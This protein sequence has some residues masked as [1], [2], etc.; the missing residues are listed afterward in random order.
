MNKMIK[1]AVGGALVAS[2]LAMAAP[3]SAGQYVNAQ[4][5]VSEIGNYTYG[6][7]NN[8]SF[9]NGLSLVGTWGMDIPAVFKYFGIEAEVSKSGVDPKAN[10]YN[11]FY[12]YP[13][14]VKYDYY[15]GGAYAVF[16]IP[17]ADRLS[18]RARGGLVY[19]HWTIKNGGVCGG[20]FVGGTYFPP[21]NCDIS[22]SDINPSV[23]GGVAY[24]FNDKLNFI[25]ELTNFDISNGNF[26][27]SAGAQFRF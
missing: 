1:N 11:W 3:A 24:Q 23:S 17:V 9:D 8:Y 21:T 20:F 26:H 10:S 5:A 27:L 2:A 16:T 13:T 19:N 12:G 15:T 14:E 7:G 4:L 22:G 6:F 25:A 18:V